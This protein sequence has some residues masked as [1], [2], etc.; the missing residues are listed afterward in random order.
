MKVSSW[1]G[2]DESGKGD[3]FG[4]LVVAAVHIDSKSLAYLSD[5]GI[6]DCKK[7]ADNKVKKLAVDIKNNCIF[8]VVVIGN[9]KYNELYKKFNNLNIMLGWAHA[10]AIENV[11]N[12]T[13]CEYVL[14]DK[15]AD[16]KVIL[17]SLMAKGKTIKLE[18][19]VR[20]EDDMA[21]AAASILAR[22]E[23][24]NRLAKMSKD[25]QMT[26][27]KGASAQVLE[28]AKQF[29]AKNGS[30]ALGDVAKLHFKTTKTV[31]GLNK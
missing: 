23:F 25:L 4:P 20:A 28:Q 2:T 8:D 6:R 15:F 31:L 11:L 12:K 9:A 18:Q 7:V 21:V 16:H 19:R 3:Y 1:I 14:A 13:D 24:L 22:A 29:V 26:F 10:R 27:G 5:L 30:A 17:N